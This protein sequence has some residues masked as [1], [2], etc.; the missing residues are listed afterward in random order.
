MRGDMDGAPIRAFP[1][2]EERIIG[3]CGWAS[4]VFVAHFVSQILGLCYEART[5]TLN[6]RPFSPSSDFSWKSFRLGNAFFSVDLRRS[7]GHIQCGVENQNGT[8]VKAKIELIVDRGAK[9]KSI[10][11]NGEEY[12]GPVV[13][14]QFFDS[15]T[16]NIELVVPPK[17]ESTI[18]V[19]Y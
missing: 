10:V 6:F 16:L 4:G 7:E 3:K 13:F 17:Q 18:K 8:S 14:G 11:V 2:G 5:K 15:V 1:V 12:Q 9:P 19:N